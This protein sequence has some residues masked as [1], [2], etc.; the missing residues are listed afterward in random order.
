MASTLQSDNL[1]R[2]TYCS[3]SVSLHLLRGLGAVVLIV[4]TVTYGGAYAWLLPP[5]FEIDAKLA[6]VETLHFLLAVA[7]QLSNPGVVKQQTTFPEAVL[8][9]PHLVGSHPVTTGGPLPGQ[10]R[11]RARKW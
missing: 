9:R 5:L 8:A 2:S 10:Q 1:D 3:R 11:P 4:L 6:G 7:E